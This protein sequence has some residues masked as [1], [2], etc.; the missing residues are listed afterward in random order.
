MIYNTTYLISILEYSK[1]LTNLSKLLVSFA[2]R[3]FHIPSPFEI[4]LKFPRFSQRYQ[5]SITAMSSSPR[6]V[7]ILVSFT[8]IKCILTCYVVLEYYYYHLIL[9][10]T[11]LHISHY[12]HLNIIIRSQSVN[13]HPPS[14]SSVFVISLMALIL[15]RPTKH[16]NSRSTIQLR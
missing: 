1:I 8:V 5:Y 11:V 4:L 15:H 13:H 12:H 10:I 6:L 7:P 2:Y 14:F 3:Y 9:I 16:N